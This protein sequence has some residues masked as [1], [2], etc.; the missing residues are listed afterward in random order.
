MQPS[1]RTKGSAQ[2]SCHGL[3]PREQRGARRLSWGWGGGQS[4][5]LRGCR[6]A[7]CYRARL[8]GGC[9]GPG[10]GSVTPVGL[11]Q[12]GISYNPVI[13]LAI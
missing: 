9:V 11:C 8:W 5:E 12:L 6:T 3:E 4:P 7:L 2:P 1:F 10:M 13:T